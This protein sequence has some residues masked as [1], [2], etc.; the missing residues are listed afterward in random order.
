M[1]CPLSWPTPGE[2]WDCPR[3]TEKSAAIASLIRTFRWVLAPRVSALRSTEGEGVFCHLPPRVS[4]NGCLGFWQWLGR[5][6]KPLLTDRLLCYLGFSKLPWTLSKPLPP[7]RLNGQRQVLRA[8]SDTTTI[9]KVKGNQPLI[10]ACSY[11]VYLTY[12]LLPNPYVPT[13]S[14]VLRSF[15]SLSLKTPILRIRTVRECTLDDECKQGAAT[16]TLF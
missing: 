1:P 3:K 11:L 6:S 14:Y 15:C 5:S 13:G 4:L 12:D 9:R 10:L 2:R 8:F 16:F 7:S